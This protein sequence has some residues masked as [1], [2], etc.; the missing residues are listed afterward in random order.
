MSTNTDD[1]GMYKFEKVRAG[2]FTV[3]VSAAGFY[4]PKK[5]NEWDSGTDLTIAD[6][7]SADEINFALIRGAVVTGRLFDERGRS[8]IEQEV[9]LMKQGADGKKQTIKCN[10]RS[11]DRGIYRCYGVEPGKYIV[12]AGADPKEGDLQMYQGRQY[13]RA[14]FP[15]VR[16]EDKATTIDVKIEAESAGIDIKLSQR[17][18]GYKALGKVIDAVSG[19]PV[20][21]IMIASGILNENGDM[22]GYTMGGIFS[23]TDGEF[24]LS[25]L[26]TGKYRAIAMKSDNGSDYQGNSSPV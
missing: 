13:L 6:N 26:T 21:M 22:S 7:D 10:D 24:T 25:G 1:S 2:Q 19:K 11:D 4:N 5:R 16:D 20:P 23:N 3:G 12:G 15:G 9:I 17:K 14:W 8:I 18:K